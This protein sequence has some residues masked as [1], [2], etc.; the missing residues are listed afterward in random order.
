MESAPAVFAGSALAVFG[1]GLLLWI[2]VRTRAGRP[3]VEEVAGTARHQP[4][5]VVLAGLFGVISLI[6][7][8][9]LLLTV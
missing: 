1:T 2:T 8:V 7:G 6:T 9:W 3:V 5:A 4:G